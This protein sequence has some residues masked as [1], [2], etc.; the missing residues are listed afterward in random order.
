MVINLFIAVSEARG[1]L[2]SALLTLVLLDSDSPQARRSPISRPRAHDG[3]QVSVYSFMT[4]VPGTTWKGCLVED[5]IDCQ[6]CQP[7]RA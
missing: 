6:S 7:A 1:D 2:E 5:L 3:P 4:H